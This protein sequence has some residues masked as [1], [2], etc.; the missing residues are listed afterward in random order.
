MG[1]KVTT[2]SKVNITA[3]ND[4]LEQRKARFVAKLMGSKVIPKENTVSKHER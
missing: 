1:S 2:E 4:E 3:P